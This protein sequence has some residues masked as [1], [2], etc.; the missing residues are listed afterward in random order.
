MS[1]MFRLQLRSFLNAPTA[2][3]GH[4]APE[5]LRYAA[6]SS[7]ALSEQIVSKNICFRLTPRLHC[8]LHRLIR[9]S[10]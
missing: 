5:K 3:R 6:I 4:H 10:H 1:V 8:F 7:T 2:L 9:F